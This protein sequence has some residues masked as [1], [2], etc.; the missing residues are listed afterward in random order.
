[1]TP[2]N[3]L[4]LCP[5]LKSVLEAGLP[6]DEE[7]LRAIAA[8][9][10]EASPE[11]LAV[12]LAGADGSD[13]AV[14]RA[15]LLYPSDRVKIALEPDIERA[16]CSP[17][18]ARRTAEVLAGSAGRSVAVFPDGSRLDIA[19]TPDDARAFALRLR[20]ERNPARA[21]RD[22][23]DKRFDPGL[24]ARL[25]V[26][27]R[28][29]PVAP[30]DAG[31]AFL[32][33]LL[34]GT[35]AEGDTLAALAAFAPRF[36]EGLAPEESAEQGLAR[37]YRTLVGQLKQAERQRDALDQSS[38]EIMISQGARLPYL[39]EDSLRAEL[40]LLNLTA[41]A[42]GLTSA[43]ALSEIIDRDLGAS[44]D[45]EGLIARLGGLNDVF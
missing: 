16:A 7:T 32:G 44:E 29:A 41:R 42:L 2:A 33:A 37:R 27:L 31:V 8:A 43:G 4:I 5:V 15:L 34:S 18:E 19:L 25:K 6:Q 45:A 1:M 21:L 28:H 26:I 23:L 11:S 12:L 9:H 40:V 20:L 35:R 22:I 17:D 13:A 14:A 36:W 39:H 24:A 38:F 10:G 3:V 30:D